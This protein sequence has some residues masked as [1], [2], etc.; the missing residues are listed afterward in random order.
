MKFLGGRNSCLLN[1]A[2]GPAHSILWY[3]MNEYI[4]YSWGGKL[5]CFYLSVCMYT[6][7]DSQTPDQGGG[8]VHQASG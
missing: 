2:T 8:G 5:Y 6:H 3:R 4:R 1:V 7:I